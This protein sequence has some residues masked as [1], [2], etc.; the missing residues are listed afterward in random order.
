MHEDLSGIDLPK[1]AML[2]GHEGVDAGSMGFRRIARRM[3]LLFETD[4]HPQPMCSRRGGKAHRIGDVAR[5]VAIRLISSALG[6]GQNHRLVGAD[7]KIGHI[8]TLLH[9]VGA[10]GDDDTVAI[11]LVQPF[12]DA[13]GEGESQRKIE[14]KTA[15]ITEF[16]DLEFDVGQRVVQRGA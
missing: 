3:K 15:E 14:G 10:M 1:L 13:S 4:H 8:G 11:G 2:A 16:V 5:T 7:E 6:T 9:R 12:V